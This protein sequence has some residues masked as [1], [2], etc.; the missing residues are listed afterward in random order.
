MLDGNGTGLKA[1][2]V[3]VKGVGSTLLGRETAE[4]WCFVYW[5]CSSKWY[6]WRVGK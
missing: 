2:F 6:D 5:S 3:V 4:Y 1:D